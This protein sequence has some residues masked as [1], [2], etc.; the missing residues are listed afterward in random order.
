MVAAALGLLSNV[1]VAQTTF[2]GGGTGS[3]PD[4]TVSGTFGAPLNV[5]FP[6]S[7]MSG[8][9]A[10]ISLAL[11][12]TH[13]YVGD[14]EVVL[15]P[16]GVTPGN[17]GSFVIFSRV[18]AIDATSGG[19]DSDINGSYRYQNAATL[20]IWTVAAALGNTANIPPAITAPFLRGRRLFQRL[21]LTSP[22]HSAG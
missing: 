2:P 6:V 19:D 13:T 15:A 4:A 20:N 1:A 9:L 12:W 3:I 22:P 16:P 14:L 11:T 10:N 8:N 18:G 21:Q 7:G 5:T 17:V